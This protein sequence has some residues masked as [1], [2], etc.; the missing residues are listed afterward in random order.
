MA[1]AVAFAVAVAVAFA[2]AVAVTETFRIETL[3]FWHEASRRQFSTVHRKT[4]A[5]TVVDP[6][7][8]LRLVQQ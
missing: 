3:Q 2:V 6:S 8:A 4:L 7:P 5:M 1:V